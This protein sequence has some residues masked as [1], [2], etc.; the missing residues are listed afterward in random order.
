MRPFLYPEAVRGWLT[1]DEAKTLYDLAAGCRVL[2]IG[3]YCGKSTICMAQSARLVVAVDWHRGDPDAGFG[4]T[5]GEFWANLKE[6]RVADV[7]VPV[8]GRIEQVA[9]LLEDSAFD[10]CF[11]DGSHDQFS[12]KR[13]ADIARRVVK[14][15][16][17][18]AFHDWD[19]VG[20][21]VQH[22]FAGEPVAVADSLV[23]WRV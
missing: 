4:D 5:L 1:P 15:G 9:G 11:V 14:A 10:F 21:H 12:V 20:E 3:S 16:G 13:D 7:V 6:Y 18:V 8:A 19:K 2:E 23:A 17:V 22:L